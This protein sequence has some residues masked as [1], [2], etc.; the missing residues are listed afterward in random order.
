MMR[1][2]LAALLAALLPAQQRGVVRVATPAAEGATAHDLTRG[3][4]GVVLS[5]IEPLGKGRHALRYAKLRGEQWS[6]PATAAEG[7]RWFVNWADFPSV[8]DCGEELLAHW[9]VRGGARYAYGVQLARSTGD[10]WTALGSPHRDDTPTEHGFVS[11][12]PDGDGAQVFWLDGR[13]MTEDGG[14]MALRTARI[15][16]EIG[17]EAVLDA[18]VCTCCQTSAVRT[19]RGPIVFYRDHTEGE[20]R[21]IAI[22][23]RT[24][25]GWTQPAAVA[26]DGWVMPG[27][28]VNGPHA[29]ALGERVAVAWF[30]AANGKAKVK[31]AFS[32]DG[33]E[34]FCEP[35]VVDGDGPI[36]RVAV[37]CSDRGAVVCWLDADGE[38]AAVRLRHVARDGA[39][40]EIVDIDRTS[41]ARA[42]GFPRMV[43]D[44]A[45]MVVAWLVTEPRAE[46]RTALVPISA[47]AP[48]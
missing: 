42:S 22:V 10:T 24:A 12:V 37:A 33:G 3:P 34:R 11:I 2:L 36:G 45:L 27:C 7:A 13:A 18:D 25:D 14:A 21:D 38:Q 6:E 1:A 35:I 8:V 41:L 26:D 29:D 40:G 23:R 16:G 19:A 43:R 17:E 47:L 20:I 4:G 32:D 46:L 5:W 28:P 31:L 48:R 39:Q 30:T 44:G 9:L 15:G